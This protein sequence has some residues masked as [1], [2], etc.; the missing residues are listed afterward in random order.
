MQSPSRP[1]EPSCAEDDTRGASEISPST[2]LGPERAPERSLPLIPQRILRPARG[3]RQVPADYDLL[4]VIGE[5]GI[6]VVY[7]AR[8]ALIDRTVAVKMLGAGD[9]GDH[10]RQDAFLSQAV[11]TGELEHPNAE[12][13]G[14][15]Q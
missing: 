10:A 12:G 5:G 15:T 8:Q 14:W 4:T 2:A 11:V 9:T 6:G 13:E 1:E 3:G 7:A